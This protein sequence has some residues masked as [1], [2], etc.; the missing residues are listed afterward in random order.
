M[1]RSL[2]KGSQHTAIARRMGELTQPSVCAR[3]CLFR[4]FRTSEP[5]KLS[6]KLLHASENNPL[7]LNAV[8][9]VYVAITE[10]SSLM[11]APWVQ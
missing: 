5:A 4:H 2:K 10:S 8:V 9:A 7:L 11:L 3:V 1:P 6:S